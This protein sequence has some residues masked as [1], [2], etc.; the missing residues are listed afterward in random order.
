[1]GYQEVHPTLTFSNPPAPSRGEKELLS[2]TGEGERAIMGS[3]QA[4]DVC[5]F[6][7]RRVL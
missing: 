7:H 3:R 1:M 5:R 6:S 4:K 2:A